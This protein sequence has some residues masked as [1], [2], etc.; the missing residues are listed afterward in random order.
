MKSIYYF[1]RAL[2]C[3]HRDANVAGT[4]GWYWCPK[5]DEYLYQTE[6][7]NSKYYDPNWK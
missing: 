7:K 1:L 4:R 2:V 3:K 6:A 5:C